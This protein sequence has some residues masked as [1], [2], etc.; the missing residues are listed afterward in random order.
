MD[1]PAVPRATTTLPWVLPRAAGATAH[2]TA[3]DV[4]GV[5]DRDR[6]RYVYA[7]TAVVPI[8]V[9]EEPLY[10]ATV[11]LWRKAWCGQDHH[12]GTVDVYVTCR[13]GIVVGWERVKHR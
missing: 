6:G 3:M 5:A 13:T 7:L 2:E 8:A 9:G 4:V 12:A 1:E 10:R 11:T